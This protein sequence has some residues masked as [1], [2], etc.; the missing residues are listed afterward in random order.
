LIRFIGLALTSTLIIGCAPPSKAPV[1]DRMPAVKSS[2]KDWRPDLYTVKRGD[3]LYSIGLEHGYDYKEIARANNIAPPYTI[4]VGQQLK[5]KPSSPAP[6]P[7]AETESSDVVITPLDMGSVDSSVIESSTT[8]ASATTESAATTEQIVPAPAAAPII[9]GPIALREP[10]SDL[11]LN[12]PVVEAKAAPVAAPAPSPT[13]APAPAQATQEASPSPATEPAKTEAIKA[14]TATAT[15]AGITWSWPTNGKLLA[16]FNEGGSAKGIDIGG[17]TGQAI[18]AAAP[19]KVI[20]SGSDLRGYGRLV[21]IKHNDEFLSV[22][23]H[24]SKILV[25]EGQAITRGQKIAEMGNTDAD[26]VKLHFEIRRQGKS[27]N[28]TDFLPANPG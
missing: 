17:N 28:P 21:I 6:A 19:G 24:N 27:V 16:G 23:A 26:R 25:K 14:P 15:S 8:E 11:A 22:Y 1:I 9:S 5:L 7:V 2:V 18:L 3:T 20:Y 10:Y 4:Y 13:T 12:T